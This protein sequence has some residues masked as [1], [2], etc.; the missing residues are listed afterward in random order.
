MIAETPC[1]KIVRFMTFRLSPDDGE[2][3]SR[4]GKYIIKFFSICFGRI[5]TDGWIIGEPN[6]WTENHKS[7]SNITY[8]CGT[9]RF[10]SFYF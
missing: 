8:S 6:R 7:L 1:S 9:V 2:I 5:P 10:A 4:Y 3:E